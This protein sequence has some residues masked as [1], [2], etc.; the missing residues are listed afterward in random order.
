MTE[1][2]DQSPYHKY[3]VSDEENSYLWH[4]VLN[5]HG[6]HT[7]Q[8]CACRADTQTKY[9]NSDETEVQSGDVFYVFT[10]GEF[11]HIDAS[12]NPASK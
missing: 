12:I 3:K 4:T 10:G 1:I 11:Q 6:G 8:Y 5:A 7:S 9:K 2:S